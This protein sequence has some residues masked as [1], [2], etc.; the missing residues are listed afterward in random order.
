MLKIIKYTIISLEIVISSIFKQVM[1]V[2]QMWVLAFG[3]NIDVYI[4]FM[5]FNSVWKLYLH[6]SE[7]I[8]KYTK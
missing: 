6:E 7:V 5:Q 4:S 3:I 8:L 1:I 2:F